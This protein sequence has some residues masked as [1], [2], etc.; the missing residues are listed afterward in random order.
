MSDMDYT[1]SFDMDITYDSDEGF[2]IG[3]SSELDMLDDVEDVYETMDVNE[4][5]LDDFDLQEI[6]DDSNV[7]EGI[8]E[9]NTSSGEYDVFMEEMENICEAEN[10]FDESYNS[11]E[12]L[13]LD[14]FEELCTDD[15]ESQE[16]V[17]PEILEELY[18]EADNNPEQL[19]SLRDLLQS[20]RVKLDLDEFNEA[21]SGEKILT[22]EITS[23]SLE[24]RERDIEETL[25][26]YRENLRNYDVSEDVIVYSLV[27]SLTELTTVN[28]VNTEY[29]SLE[30]GDTFSNI[31]YDP[32]NW[33]SIA[34]TLA[35]TEEYTTNVKDLLVETDEEFC[36]PKMENI[37][38]ESIYE[39]IDISNQVTAEME[40]QVDEEIHTNEIDF[41]E[42]EYVYDEINDVDQITEEIGLHVEE[43]SYE[44]EIEDTEVENFYEELTDTYDSEE[45]SEEDN[46]SEE[47]LEELIEQPEVFE[48]QC[49]EIHMQDE[50]I[51]DEE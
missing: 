2:N 44:E 5:C 26:N 16:L 39:E 50:E 3:E 22:R 41:A 24:S 18:L 47:L 15:F 32:M 37:E 20:G 25:D 51:E 43:D 1:D 13:S 42:N 12:D 4:L 33:E 45:F 23:E 49:D 27:N 8:Y 6:D 35:E 29:D 34:E 30:C 17:T 40:F 36:G 9:I 21:E 7:S 46:Y 19:D 28:Q 31:Y 11:E 48:E 38:D 10:E 14:E